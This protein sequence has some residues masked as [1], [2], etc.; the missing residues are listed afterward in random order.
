[1]AL[2][3]ANSGHSHGDQL[4][5]V[6][7][8][9]DAA[10]RSGQAIFPISDSIY[11]EVSKIGTYRQRRALREVIERISGFMVVSSRSVVSVHE[12]ET[13]L[14]TLVGPSSDPINGMNYIDWGVMRAFGLHG[15]MIIRDRETGADMTEEARAN[16][17]GGPAE[18]DRI[19]WEGQFSLSRSVLDGPTPGQEEAEMRASGW[20]PRAAFKVAERRAQQ[21]IEQ[22]ARFDADPAWRRGRIRDVVAAREVIIEVNEHLWKG[23]KDRGVQLEEAFPSPDETLRIWD[24]MPSFDVAVTLKTEYHRDPNHIWKTNDITDIDALG[25]TLPYCDVVLTDKA[26]AS[27]AVR[28]GL[29]ERLGTVVHSRTSDLTRYL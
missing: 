15:G 10:A 12:I 19:V 11:F 13:M 29:A 6:L 16:H 25:S 24:S 8:A 2:A 14:D 26:A 27:H 4:K 3:K 1:M 17:P 5:E 7:E 20:N 21:E 28:T 18:F 9:C 23:L 22:V